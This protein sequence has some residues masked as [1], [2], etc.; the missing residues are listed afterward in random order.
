MRKSLFLITNICTYIYKNIKRKKFF[1]ILSKWF[2]NYSS[3][4]ILF[5]R[6]KFSRRIANSGEEDFVLRDMDLKPRI[7]WM[8][9]EAGARVVGRWE[10]GEEVEYQIC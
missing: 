1:F 6:D 2:N 5:F 10:G 4:A 3:S 8:Q 7:S 9:E